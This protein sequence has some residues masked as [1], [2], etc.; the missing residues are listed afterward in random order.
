MSTEIALAETNGEPETALEPISGERLTP[1]QAKVEAVA[2]LTMKVYERASQLELSDDE[3]RKLH[4][5]FPDTAF[6]S[7][8]GGK[9]NLIYI[10]HAYLRDRLNEV[11]APGQWAIIPRSRWGEPFKTAKGVNG[12]R[13]Y[14][15]AMLCVRG[16]FV[17][18][19]VGDMAYYPGNESTNYGDAVEG[20]KSAAL[21]RCAKELGIGLQAW[22][23]DWCEGWWKRKQNPQQQTQQPAQETQRPAE[24]VLTAL[25]T[26]QL[27]NKLAG[28]YF[29]D[30]QGATASESAMLEAI[31]V[32]APSEIPARLF[33]LLIVMIETKK[34]FAKIVEQRGKGHIGGLSD[35]G[36]Q[37]WI[38]AYKPK[39]VVSEAPP[40]AVEV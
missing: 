17:A 39:P 23:K 2:N 21:R 4:A 40:D 9:D 31:G 19:A 14:V 1:A 30:P 16:C 8:A 28:A 33:D 3:R 24:P 12:V 10:E 5:D 29:E 34:S 20:A 27:I 36:V 11:F 26:G 15:E 7:G 38:D 35:V 32:K 18:E 37:K 22:K 13:I 25:Q 6:R